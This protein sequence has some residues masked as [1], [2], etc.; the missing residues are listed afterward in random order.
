MYE[1]VSYTHLDVYKRQIVDG[2]VDSRT[3]KTLVP[4]Y[5]KT[6]TLELK[7]SGTSTV[8]IQLD[9][10]AYSCLLYTSGKAGT[11][12]SKKPLIVACGEKSVELCEIQPEGKKKMTAESFL[13]GHRLSVGD[14]IG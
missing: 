6:Y 1:A 10:Q 13:A 8:V 7:G 4:K 14:V 2:A 11:V 12:I 9:G 3:S 5:N